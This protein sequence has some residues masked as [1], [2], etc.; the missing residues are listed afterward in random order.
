MADTRI[1][2]PGSQGKNLVMQQERPSSAKAYRKVS[3]EQTPVSD[4]IETV[5]VE[6]P[7]GAR[8]CVAGVKHGTLRYAHLFR[9]SYRVLGRFIP[10]VKGNSNNKQKDFFL[11]FQLKSESL[12]VVLEF[13]LI[14]KDNHNV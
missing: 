14:F 10:V 8:V 3:R 11:H 2:L 13:V 5:P 9:P 6:L 7:I 12:F 4:R 1:P